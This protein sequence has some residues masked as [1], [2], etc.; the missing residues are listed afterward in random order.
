MAHRH[1]VPRPEVLSIGE[2]LIDFIVTDESTS[3]EAAQTFV[4]RPGGAPANVAVA[5]SRLGIP[6]AFCG[7][8][9]RDPFGG[10]LEQDLSAEGVDT[11][12]LRQ[13][14]AAATALAYAWKDGRG[15][16]HFWLLR[17]A[18]TMLDRRDIGLAAISQL[19]ALVVGSVSMATR[20]SRDAV[21]TAVSLANDAGV[22]VVF[23]INL[24]PTVWANTDDALPA[25]EAIAGRSHLVKLSLDD[26]RGLF[27]AEVSPAAV[28]ERV[29]GLGPNA[30]VLTDGERG[31]WFW[32]HDFD[33]T[34]Y[35]PAF[36][37][38]AIEPTGAGDAFCAALVVR[39]LESGWAPLKSVDVRFAAAAGALATMKRGAW[40][41]LPSREQLETFLRSV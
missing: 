24:R 3:L 11:S 37:V 16:G 9:G 23:D 34:A 12:R 41:G 7:V 13:T 33:R 20:P 5:L 29:L 32:S 27:G 18:D 26:A 35:V 1:L 17:G 28:V 40:D 36:M 4:A 30:V 19:T 31:C 15:D 6:S 21:E 10:R 14:D 2:C 25:A 8:V 38:E 22:P 39:L